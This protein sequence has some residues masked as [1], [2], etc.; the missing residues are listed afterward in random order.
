MNCC[1]QC[2]GIEDLFNTRLAED[3]LR[4]YRKNGPS[5][6]TRLLLDTLRAVGVEG[7]TL[8]DIGGG[9]GAIQHELMKS[10]LAVTIDVGA[11]SA[12]LSAAKEEAARQGY[13]DRARY[14]HGN[15]IDLAPGLENADIVTLDRVICCFPDMGA[16]VSLSATRAKRWYA[17]VYPRDTWWMRMGGRVGNFVLALGRSK[18]RFFVHPAQAVDSLVRANGLQPHFQ[19]NTGLFWQVVV[20]G[21]N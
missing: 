16:M 2:Q 12:Y 6:Q 9:I 7:L 18:F 10:G 3:D 19:R 1:N 8:L 13:A 20:Y 21:R 5:K 14:F 15:F 17:L 4:A 11:S